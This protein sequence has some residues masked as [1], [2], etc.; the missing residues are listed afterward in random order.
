MKKKRVEGKR[1]SNSSHSALS[2]AIKDLETELNSLSKEKTTS[3]RLLD[4]IIS[5][6]NIDRSKERELQ[7][8]IA[9]LIEKEADLNEKKKKLQVK[10]E[11]VSDKISKISKIK[12]EMSD[13]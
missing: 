7:Q 6:V 2:S 13:V 8:R 4:S 5:A 11:R 1:R 10:I 3:K 12:S 9:R